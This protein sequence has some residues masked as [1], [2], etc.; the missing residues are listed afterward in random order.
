MFGRAVFVTVNGVYMGVHSRA[1]GSRVRISQVADDEFV[2]WRERRFHA[3]EVFSRTERKSDARGQ[4]SVCVENS[5]HATAGDTELNEE[6]EDHDGHEG[7]LGARS[8]GAMKTPALTVVSVSGKTWFGI[9]PLAT[10]RII[11]SR[12][13]MR[14]TSLRSNWL[15]C[16]ACLEWTHCVGLLTSRWTK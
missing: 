14:V 6:H 3:Y 13:E 1:D 5:V 11:L 10:A 2:S 15:P 12:V 9:L 7:E 4:R 8:A 16:T